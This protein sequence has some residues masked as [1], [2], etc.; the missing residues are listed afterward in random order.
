MI[1]DYYYN[2]NVKP[3]QGCGE[4]VPTTHRSKDDM[5]WKVRHDN[6]TTSSITTRNVTKNVHRGHL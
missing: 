4:N 1:L 3:T 2:N 6:L 5:H